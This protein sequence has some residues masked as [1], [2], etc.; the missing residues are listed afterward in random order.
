MALRKL[1]GDE[2]DK[3]IRRVFQALRIAVNDEFTVLDS[4]CGICLRR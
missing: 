1:A 2:Q 4:L 3:A